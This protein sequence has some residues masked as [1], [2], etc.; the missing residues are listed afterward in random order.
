MDEPYSNRIHRTTDWAARKKRRPGYARR[1][2]EPERKVRSELDRLHRRHVAPRADR[3]R[4]LHR[5]IRDFLQGKR[6]PKYVVRASQKWARKP[7]FQALARRSKK[8]LHDIITA[9]SGGLRAAKRFQKTLMDPLGKKNRN[10]KP[11]A[12]PPARR[13]TGTL[14]GLAIAFLAAAAITAFLTFRAVRDVVASWNLTDLPGFSAAQEGTPAAGGEIGVDINVPLQPS[15][16]PT[17]QPWDGA[18]RVS[19]LVMGLDYR[20]WETEQGAPRTDTMILFTI[21][22]LSRTAGMLSIP[23]DL[24]V[25][26]PGFEP[27]KINTAYRF[28]EVYDLPGGGPGLAMTTVE[29]LLGV[30]INFYALIDFY[31]FDRFIDELGGITIN[32]PEE[33]SVDPL[34]PA[35]TVVLEPGEQELGGSIALA[36][37]R[38]RNSEGGDFDR[39]QRQQQVTLAIRNKIL[40]FDLLP[41]LISK[42]PVLYQEIAA[43]VHTNLT[44]EQSIRLG[45]LASQI[46]EDKI[47][48]GVIGPP[49]HVTFGISPDGLDILRPVPDQIR[50]LRDQVFTAEAGPSPAALTAEPE[51][52]VVAESARVSVLNG[53][54]T[55]GLAATTSEF[56]NTKGFNV[57]VTDNAAQSYNLTT[58]IVYSGKPYTVQYLVDTLGI[59]ANR[60]FFSYDPANAIDIEINL[61]EDWAANNTLN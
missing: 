40:S 39:A 22:P 43:G 50:L 38:A 6:T 54:F 16:G 26:I 59:S 20:D 14:V 60:I 58:L 8:P 15:A 7:D 29:E 5:R 57:T 42:A 4:R 53:T 46:Q 37:A 34:G 28:G 35:N 23:R 11:H 56:L 13:S 36:Y 10:R 17:P 30:P 31:A 51:E 32:V 18:S 21:D 9:A 49:E 41:V 25:N 45:V 44:L 55:P 47:S 52:L 12:S 27:N 33:I 2:S 3:V 61:G 24:W 1:P 48:R 19:V